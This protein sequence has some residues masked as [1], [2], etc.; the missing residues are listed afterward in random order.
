[1]RIGRGKFEHDGTHMEGCSSTQGDGLFTVLPLV[2]H[3]MHFTVLNCK[4]SV[5]FL[6]ISVALVAQ[7]L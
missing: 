6:H 7:H 4:V 1:M 2:T 5:I 3:A